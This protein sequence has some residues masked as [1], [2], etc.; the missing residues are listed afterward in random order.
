MTRKIINIIVFA[1]AGVAIL[2]TFFFVGLWSSSVEN[3]SSDVEKAN[4]TSYKAI[5]TLQSFD[6]GQA[7]LDKFLA[8]N[9]DD[10][11]ST[12]KPGKLYNEINQYVE[13]NQVVCETEEAQARDF[14]CYMNILKSLKEKDFPE[15]KKNFPHN[16]TSLTVNGE[17]NEFTFGKEYVGAFKKV[18]NYADLNSYITEELTNEYTQFKSAQLDKENQLKAVKSLQSATDSIFKISAFDKESKK[19]ALTKFQGNFTTYKTS[20]SLLS[21]SFTLIYI[22]FAVAFV[23]ILFFIIFNVCT[24]FKNSYT[25]LLILGGLAIVGLISFLIA[26]PDVNNIVFAKLSISPTLGRFIE[27]SAYMTYVMLALAIL[28]M[29][30]TPIIGT[31]IKNKKLK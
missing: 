30:F 6:E 20:E 29:I 10:I 22:L 16:M 23:A 31:I 8:A 5:G 24:D 26:K 13:K 3:E 14:F 1:A 9:I 19:N 18:N 17:G 12:A 25:I 2:L 28:G 21:Y 4:V 7:L 27:A 11:G 15:F